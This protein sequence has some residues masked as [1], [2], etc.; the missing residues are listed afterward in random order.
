M[1]DEVVLKIE[2]LD[3]ASQ[4][5]SGMLSSLDKITQAEKRLQKAAQDVSANLN[6]A[7]FQAGSA[8]I[9]N[10]STRQI[11]MDEHKAEQQRIEVDKEKEKIKRSQ[12]PIIDRPGSK[13]DPK[14]VKAAAERAAAASGV[15]SKAGQ[16]AS[17]GSS[18]AFGMIGRAGPWGAAIAAGAMAFKTV[19][20][21]SSKALD[22]WNSGILTGAQKNEALRSQFV[23]FYESIKKLRES[24]DGTTETLARNQRRLAT[25]QA[26]T[27]AQTQYRSASFGATAEM[28]LLAKRMQVQNFAGGAIGVP[29]IDR[30]TAKGERESSDRDMILPAQDARRR[31]GLELEAR[32]RHARDITGEAPPAAGK[33]RDEALARA[34]EGKG[35][36]ADATAYR[37]EMEKR[38]K[39]SQD[40]LNAERLKEQNGGPRNKAGISDAATRA[41]E[42][43]LRLQQAQKME[44]EKIQ[45]AIEA[46]KGALEAEKAAR[47]ANLD[48]MRGQLEIEKA[49]EARMAGLA[50]KLGS[51]NQADYQMTKQALQQVK[52]S[53]IENVPQ[54]IADMAAQAAPEFIAKQREKLGEQ[55]AKETA[56]E[57]KGIDDSTL[58]AFENETLAE[59]RG[60]VDKIKADVR[61]QID[62]D[63]QA[64]AKA[65]VD[66]LGPLFAGF[67]TSIKVYMESEIDKFKVANID[68]YNSQH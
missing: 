5:L 12:G 35:S 40:K 15:A 24:L 67:L 11:A 59:V 25:M 31:A 62:L 52:E 42:D 39:A 51:M 64:M 8:P 55:R 65:A 1:A 54:E 53:G 10:K 2:M 16:L 34:S 27:A 33:A 45:K 29:T 19:L 43:L 49:K 18:A 68:K 28:D 13:P 6:K 23:P 63:D 58:G 30:S 14:M 36:M 41:Q 32:R 57:N 20:D 7:N 37:Q 50:Q 22:V 47:Q 38:A 48:I 26:T 46:G 3:K 44:Q 66:Q 17:G 9:T 56:G 4:T 21:Q 61:I 60:K